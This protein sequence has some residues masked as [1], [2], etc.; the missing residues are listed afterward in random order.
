MA[1]ANAIVAFDHT[2][3]SFSQLEWAC[4]ITLIFDAM[5][6]NEDEKKPEETKE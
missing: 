2:R 4:K 5:L 1:E 6:S 3:V